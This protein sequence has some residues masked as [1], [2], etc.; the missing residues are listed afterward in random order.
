ML[1]HA[2]YISHMVC[3]VAFHASSYLKVYL[4]AVFHGICYSM[5]R[6]QKQQAR[7]LLPQL[8]C[9]TVSNIFGEL[10]AYV[11]VRSP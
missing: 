7:D 8:D 9:R 1:N 10:S 11:S 4:M 2:F 6:C 5:D 3:Q